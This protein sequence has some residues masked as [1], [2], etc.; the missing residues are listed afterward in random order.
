[1]SKEKRYRLYI[2]ESGDHT[3]HLV[4]DDNHR[5][6][7]LLGLWFDTDTP[8]KAYAQALS[9]LKRDIF[10]PHPDDPIICLHRKD[11][12]ERR[13]VFRR[14]RNPDLNERFEREL[15]RVVR[16]AH[17]CMTSVVIDKA[18]HRTKT[19][20]ELFH[21]YHYCL[22]ALLERYAG[23]LEL[24]GSAGDVMAESRG[25]R[26]DEEL[27]AAF[28]IT[29]QKGTRFHSP[30]QF[31]AVL[32]S[33][34]IKLKKKEHAIAGLELAD[35]LAYP[36]KREMIAE[37]RGEDLPED[38]SAALLDT[39]RPKMNCQAFTRRVAGYGKVWLE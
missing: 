17:F 33:V 18:S 20:R 21:P 13:G 38:F 30:E 16:E 32:T 39:A 9:D 8:Y 15:L 35:L 19:Y 11:L 26:E 4:D 27:R 28:D 36:F 10:E 14:L 23:W 2:D 3:F 22:V 29:L 6:L 34:D 5:Y 1:M 12:I 37:R 24:E 31:Q 25:G 7:G